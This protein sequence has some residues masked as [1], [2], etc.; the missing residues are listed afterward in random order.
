MR[1]DYV[2]SP[3]AY[4][5]MIAPIKFQ[6]YQ[7]NSDSI[8]IAGAKAGVLQHGLNRQQKKQAYDISME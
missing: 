1:I 7:K 2:C 3:L 4:D 6:R 8:A 5:L